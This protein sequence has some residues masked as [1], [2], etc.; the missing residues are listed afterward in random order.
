MTG[1]AGEEGLAKDI[2]MHVAAASPDFLDPA[3]VPETLIAQERD[4]AK[5]QMKGKPDNII[6]KILG[7][8]IESFYDQVCLIRQNIFAT[9]PSRL[10]NW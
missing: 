4:I 6:E 3:D 7:G 10:D 1:A 2:A 8:K 5:E 9:T